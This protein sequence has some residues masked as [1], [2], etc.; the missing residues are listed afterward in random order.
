MSD[1]LEVSHRLWV[2][3]CIIGLSGQEVKTKPLNLMTGRTWT[4]SVFGGWKCRSELPKL[5]D[6]V[7]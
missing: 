3:S 4:G 1:A 5:V 7:V 2:V 6:S